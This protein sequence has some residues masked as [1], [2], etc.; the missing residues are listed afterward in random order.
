MHILSFV[1]SDNTNFYRQ[2]VAGLRDRGHTV[3]VFPVPGDIGNDG[4]RAGRRPVSA[5][6]WYFPHAILGEAGEYDV[7]HAN[8]GLT[9]PPAVVQPFHPTVLTLWGSDVTG[10]ISLLSRVCS[11]FADAVVVMSREMAD[12]IGCDCHVIP[13]G[14]DLETFRPLSQS[15]AREEVGWGCE[16]HQVLFP[17]GP[18]RAVKNFSRAK[19]VVNLARVRLDAPVELQ[20]MPGVPH[21]HVPW[22]M[23]AADAMLLTSKRE[24]SPNTVKE[25]LACNLP[26]VATN[27]GDIARQLDDV[28]LSTANDDDEVLVDGLV[29]A[30]Q[31]G[32]R[33]NGRESI[34][35]L[36]LENQLDRIEAVY[37]LVT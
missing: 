35:D 26:V 13:H 22:Y 28:T 20:T 1:T 33:S 2:Q 21:D 37:E 16:A 27:V 19:H 12:I 25:A 29:E 32:E 11:R 30:L 23:N 36:G 6:F 3:D 24:R 34:I 18:S 5:C 9:G 14:I 7:V 17:Y 4:Y 15:T 31:S 10:S 8:Y